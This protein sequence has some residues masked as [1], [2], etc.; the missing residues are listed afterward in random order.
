VKNGKH[1]IYGFI[2]CPWT[3]GAKHVETQRTVMSATGFATGRAFE[4]TFDLCVRGF[5]V[6]QDHR[7]MDAGARWNTPLQT[8]HFVLSIA[9]CT[10]LNYS[11]LI[12]FLSS[13]CLE[14][15]LVH[16]TELF[17]AHQILSFCKKNFCRVDI[18]M[19]ITKIFYYEN[20]ELSGMNHYCGSWLILQWKYLVSLLAH[21]PPPLLD[22]MTTFLSKTYKCLISCPSF[23]TSHYFD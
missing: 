7:R 15:C 23:T 14:C 11:V 6:Y 1:W 12:K 16:N 18:V 8:L 10:I 3:Q 13:F 4:M 21:F 9:L 2:T 20:L 19:K 22:D 5:H 17:T